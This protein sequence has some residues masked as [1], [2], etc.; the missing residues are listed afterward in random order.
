MAQLYLYDA[1]DTARKSANNAIDSYAKGAEKALLKFLMRRML[2]TYN[3][4]PKDVRRE[5]ADFMIKQNGYYF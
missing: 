1:L 5:V 2:R 4:N 3:I